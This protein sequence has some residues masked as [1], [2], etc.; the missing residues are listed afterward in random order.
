MGSE[1]RRRS[2]EKLKEQREKDK[3]RAKRNR[4][5]IVVGVAA[6]VVLLSPLRGGRAEARNVIRAM[7]A[8][9]GMRTLPSS[10]V[11]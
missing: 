3:R 11:D 2:R 8:A 1:A 10:S 9:R 7:R 5:L 6:A 4:T